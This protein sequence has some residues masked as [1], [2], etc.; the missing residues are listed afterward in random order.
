MIYDMMSEDRAIKQEIS[1]NM[2]KC[3]C[4]VEDICEIVYENPK[5]VSIFCGIYRY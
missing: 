3:A 2:Q 1:E 5:Y 4:N